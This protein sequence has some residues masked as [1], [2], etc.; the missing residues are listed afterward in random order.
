MALTDWVQ[1]GAVIYFAW[2][3][4]R[5]FRQQNK[6]IANQSKKTAMPI[7][8]SRFRF[9]TR[10]W[11]TI[12]MI[13]LMVLTAY[14]IYDRHRATPPV[15]GTLMTYWGSSTIGPQ[16]IESMRL[17]VTTNG[18]YFAEY[19]KAARLAAVAF[20]YYGTGDVLDASGLQK[21]GLF[22]ITDQPISLLIQVDSE[23]KN[24]MKRGDTE[25]MYY[26]L[27]VPRD[28]NM[29]QFNTLRQAQ[30]AGVKLLE[31]HGGPP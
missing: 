23:Y 22:D 9:L 30:L 7:E 1:T 6:I 29:D 21:S 10:Y 26:L 19:K 2:Q 14:D 25:T 27:L 31:S 4:N 8:T 16:P 3:Q 11:P 20:R 5:I 18:L 28:V 13:G 12:T 17:M 24:T 15:P